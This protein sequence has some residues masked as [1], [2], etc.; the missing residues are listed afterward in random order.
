MN[1]G[2]KLAE[3]HVEVPVDEVGPVV[4]PF[5]EEKPE[6]IFPLF[7]HVEGHLNGPALDNLAEVVPVFKFKHVET[8]KSFERSHDVLFIM[9]EVEKIFS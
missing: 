1:D 3:E 2:S 9:D 8:D 6:F 5:F 4:I 7:L